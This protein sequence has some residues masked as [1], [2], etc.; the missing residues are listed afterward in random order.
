MMET[1]GFHSMRMVRASDK[2]REFVCATGR[3]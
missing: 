3:K 1:S 2:H